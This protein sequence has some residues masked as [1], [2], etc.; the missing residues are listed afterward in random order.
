MNTHYKKGEATAV[1][2][3]V[4]VLVLIT[5]LGWIFYQNFIYKAPAESGDGSLVA[6]KDNP[7]KDPEA[8]PELKEG[9]LTN[10]KLCFK[11][12]EGWVH[13]PGPQTSKA[14]DGTVSRS[15][16]DKITSPSGKLVLV[17]EASQHGGVGSVCDPNEHKFYHITVEAEETPLLSQKREAGDWRGEMMHAVK[18]IFYNDETNTFSPDIL[19]T[20]NAEMAKIGKHTPCST[21]LPHFAGAKNLGGI[22]T[23]QMYTYDPPHQVKNFKF[24]TAEEA[25][26]ELQK[27]EY[28]QAFDIVRSVYYK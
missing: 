8:A 12:P 1:I 19:L 9:C 24:K 21:E 3:T 6:K 18:A 27:P 13:K 5:A 17:A 14:D 20:E 28:N 23:F 11:Y 2:M 15:D 22:L 4:L 25:R 7:N 16:S 10:E 26:Q